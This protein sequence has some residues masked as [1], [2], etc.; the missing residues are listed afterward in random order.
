MKRKFIS[1]TKTAGYEC[2]TALFVALDVSSPILDGSD[3][4]YSGT[5][6]ENLSEDTDAFNWG[7][8]YR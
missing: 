5:G 2:P 6:I 8:E 3:T 1:E 4:V 7:G